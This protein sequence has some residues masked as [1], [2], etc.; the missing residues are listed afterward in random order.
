MKKVISICFFSIFITFLAFSQH[1]EGN[2]GK[3]YYDS[4]KTKL[5][6]VYSYKEVNVFSP[7]GDHSIVNVIQKKHGPYF[8]YYEN[9]KI[10]VKGSYK[11]DKKDGE[12]IYMDEHGKPIKTEKY[13]D[14]ELEGGG[15]EETE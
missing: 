6:E 13:V 9:G 8:Y 12:W 14:G 5:K 7:T 2:S 4:A 11:N 1:I 3:T 10:K 15:E